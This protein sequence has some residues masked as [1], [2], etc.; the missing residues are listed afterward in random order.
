M[1]AKNVL[2]SILKPVLPLLVLLFLTIQVFH[3]NPG[4]LTFSGLS[5][6]KQSKPPYI[7]A[8]LLAS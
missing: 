1:L 2:L 5:C 4:V 7:K 8:D 6:S 3:G